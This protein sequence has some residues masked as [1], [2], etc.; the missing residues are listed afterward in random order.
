MHEV[1]SA[2]TELLSR[3]PW[4]VAAGSSYLATSLVTLV[5]LVLHR[6][7]SGAKPGELPLTTGEWTR[8]MAERLG[9]DVEVGPTPVGSAGMDAYFP[10]ARY[11]AL[12]DSTF[13]RR[14]PSF[15][16]IGA[17]ELGHA[18]H[19][20]L[21]G[22]GHLFTWAR[23]VDI[24]L[25]R[26][27]SG[28]MVGVALVGGEVALTA[29]L[30]VLVAS[31]LAQVVVLVDESWASYE[32]FRWL[33]L[34]ATLRPAQLRRAAWALA[35]ALLAYLGSFGA[36]LTLIVVWPWLSATAPDPA[37]PAS[38][39]AWPALLFLGAL[40]LPMLKR[41]FRIAWS[42]FRPERIERLSDLGVRLIKENAGDLG[43][44]LGALVFCA[45]ALTLPAHPARDLAVMLAFTPAL[46][47]I[48]AIL[49]SVVQ[50]PLALLVL[51]VDRVGKKADLLAAGVVPDDHLPLARRLG[52][53]KITLA[54][55]N[56]TSLP[57]RLLDLVRIAYLPLIVV[58]W[59]TESG[60]V[61]RHVL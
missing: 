48:A 60:I 4:F 58:F 40:T 16:A 6:A 49:A 50:I 18:A 45:F 28:A 44:G 52:S 19:A 20:R 1:E 24:S 5:Y 8:A 37:L 56:D 3:W 42:A 36:R 61:A 32:G 7:V 23:G 41:A 29:A 27:L 59:F 51:E 14:D 31:S 39:V 30:A 33:R 35:A 26:L 15:W 46:A 54:I 13:H 11:V 2:V 25:D 10:S 53:P 43:G 47:P 57:R 34:D 17:H 38:G 9:L 12:K 22:W 21:P 55:H